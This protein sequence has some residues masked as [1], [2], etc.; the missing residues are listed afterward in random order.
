MRIILDRVRD[1]P[2]GFGELFRHHKFLNLLIHVAVVHPVAVYFAIQLEKKLV[3]IQRV[4]L[5]D[6]EPEK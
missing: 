6:T 4:F 1:D 3:I 5:L 2:L